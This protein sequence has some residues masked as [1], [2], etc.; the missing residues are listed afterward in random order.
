[1][2][3]ISLTLHTQTV[4]TPVPNITTGLPI[5]THGKRASQRIM[6]AH[7]TYS[8]TYS[9]M[10]TQWQ[11][12]TAWHAYTVMHA[13]TQCQQRPSNNN[14]EECLLPATSLQ[15]QCGSVYCQQHPSNN[16]VEE[17]LLLATSLQQQCGRV[18]ID[19]NVPPTT[20]WKSAYFFLD[21]SC[22]VW[23]SKKTVNWNRLSILGTGKHTDK[24]NTVI[25]RARYIRSF[26]LTHTPW[27]SSV[28]VLSLWPC[29]HHT[30]RQSFN[31]AM[32]MVTVELHIALSRPMGRSRCYT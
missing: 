28:H 4:C 29:W 24:N 32:V 19:S 6:Y 25:E 22:S 17:C 2:E 13:H 12:Y 11:T 30:R 27:L 31:K 18:F 15:Q 23:G 16:N 20:M 1:M 26:S 8:N 7:T 10:H 14:V 21:N 9:D 3:P 5:Y